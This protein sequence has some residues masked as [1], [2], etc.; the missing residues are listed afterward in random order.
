[1]LK[2]VSFVYLKFCFAHKN[3]ICINIKSYH[4]IRIYTCI[5]NFN[6]R[7]FLNLILNLKMPKS[8]SGHINKLSVYGAEQFGHKIVYYYIKIL[9]D[10]CLR[11]ILILKSI[12][13]CIAICNTFIIFNKLRKSDT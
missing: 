7:T 10:Y 2:A 4:F 11:Q 5:W 9:Q 13:L 8:N 6:F 1:M 12:I 3:E